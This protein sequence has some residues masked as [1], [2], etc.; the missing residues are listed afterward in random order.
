M[1]SL[2]HSCY[3]CDKPSGKSSNVNNDDA[4]WLF[5]F[6]LFGTVSHWGTGRE[7]QLKSRLFVLTTSLLFFAFSDLFDDERRE[8]LPHQPNFE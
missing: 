8:H 6:S 4:A 7:G 2:L 5:F 1:R 3:N